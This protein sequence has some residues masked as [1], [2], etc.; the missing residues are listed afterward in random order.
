[1]YTFP[2]LQ[3][4]TLAISVA[5]I[6]SLRS[7]TM[8]ARSKVEGRPC[9]SPSPLLRQCQRAYQLIRE[10]AGADDDGDDHELP[11]G[12]QAACLIARTR[13]SAS[14]EGVDTRVIQTRDR[15]RRPAIEDRG[16]NQIIDADRR[17]HVACQQ[18]VDELDRGRRPLPGVRSWRRVHCAHIEAMPPAP[19]SGSCGRKLISGSRRKA[20]PKRPGGGP[21]AAYFG[22][23]AV[24]PKYPPTKASITSAA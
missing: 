2:R 1:M 23:K 8:R 14:D 20:C 24:S 19:N 6:P 16:G 9:K 12:T 18:R 11:P 17:R 13:A 22:L 21:L 4:M 15:P 7:D 3:P 10:C 5:P